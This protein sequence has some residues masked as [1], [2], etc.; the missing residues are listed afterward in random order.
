MKKRNILFLLLFGVFV[1]GIMILIVG[2]EEIINAVKNADPFYIGLA[3]FSQFVTL[4]LLTLRWALVINSLSIRV[5]KRKLFPMLLV[6]MMINNITPSG[7]GGGEPVR[8][9]MLSRSSD[10]SVESAFATVIVDR[11]LDTFPMLFLALITIISMVFFFELNMAVIIALVSTVVVISLIFFVFMYMCINES[12]GEKIVSW[13]LKIIRKFYTKEQGT[14]EVKAYEAL[15]NF[16]KSFKLMIR[17]KKVAI[18]GILVSCISWALEIVRVYFVFCAFGV[19]ASIIVIAEVF[20][21]S[22]LLGIIP[23]LPGGLGAV[24]GS[25]VLLYSAAGITSSISAAVT[26]VERLISFWMVSA[27]GAIC[28][29]LFGKQV[30][31]HILDKSDDV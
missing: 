17:D 15:A 29:P 22:C 11:A 14:L 2:P 7:R 13:A 26:V 28:L 21:I 3:V 8:A 24:D 19:N 23:L 6:G 18:Y 16:Q 4:I 10:C 20:I 12:A 1:V 27:L 9:Y 5:P 30:F 25:M 31:E